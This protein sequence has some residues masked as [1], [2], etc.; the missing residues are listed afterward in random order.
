MG[1]GET[2]GAPVV[3]EEGSTEGVGS[4]G[5][6][7]PVGAGR[8]LG[9]SEVAVS[10]VVGSEEGKLVGDVGTLERLGEEVTV[11]AIEG[12]IVVGNGDESGLGVP[13]GDAGGD[14]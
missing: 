13:E 7:G 6:V 8:K 14:C 11:G 5:V 10:V 3:F 12:D 9:D 4:V 1:A 2:V